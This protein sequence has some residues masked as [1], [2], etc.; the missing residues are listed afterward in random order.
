MQIEQLVEMLAEDAQMRED[1][2]IV[3]ESMSVLAPAAATAL[4]SG[5]DIREA[6]TKHI[7]HLPEA[8]NAEARMSAAINRTM[9]KVALLM[10]V[11]ISSFMQ[12]QQQAQQPAEQQT[13]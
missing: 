8:L 3:A 11:I 13:A 1:L 6:L 4:R 5:G 7:K 9:D 10:P 12:M 2:A